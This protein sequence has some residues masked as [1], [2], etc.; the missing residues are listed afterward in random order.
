VVGVLGVLRRGIDEPHDPSLV[1][2]DIA[3]AASA[4]HLVLPL[5][6]VLA[7]MPVSGQVAP[8][9]V[10]PLRVRSPAWLGLQDLETSPGIGETVAAQFFPARP[11][12]LGAK[13][14]IPL[15]GRRRDRDPVAT[16][17]AQA[18]APARPKSPSVGSRAAA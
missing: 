6:Q 12:F 13:A 4:G 9:P 8:Q 18:G 5:L 15:A 16:P 10:L 1:I 2:D 3:N 7:V 14:H 11:C 17:G